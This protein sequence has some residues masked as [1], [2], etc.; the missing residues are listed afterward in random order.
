MTTLYEIH[1][2]KQS[3][4]KDTPI[5]DISDL[6]IR[7]EGITGL[8]GPNGSGKS[9]LLKVLSFLMPYDSGTLLYRGQPA[10][11]RES[12]IRRE[13][14]YLLQ[15]SFL[16]SR[17]VFE[18]IAFGLRLRGTSASEVKA[19]VRESLTRVGLD[20][21][22]FA[23]RQWYQ[24]SGGE[25][26]RVALAARLA[27]RPRVLLLDEPTA[28][29]DEASAQLIMAAAVTEAEQHGTAVIVATHDM[30]WLYEMSAEII[31]LYRGRVTAGAENILQGGWKQEGCHMVRSFPGGQTVY[32]D[33]T[34]TAAVRA[35][36]LDPSCVRV[37]LSRPQ[38]AD[39][40]NITAGHV[41]H[42]T[43]ERGRNSVLVTADVGGS[44]LKAR[45]PES[46]PLCRELY[47]QREVFY[48]FPYSSVRWL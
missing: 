37:S 48:I 22:E 40:V 7:S 16:L 9:T 8:V 44:L 26:Q 24:L 21:D 4:R 42:L 46:D 23:P 14:T 19:I 45:V 5:L 17:S 20:P 47:P 32:A 34:D 27:L 10:A 33:R 39:S 38:P 43:L 13:V 29:V 3:Y 28:N 18:N 41:V 11:G 15:N 1:N 12:V 30:P 35:A 6:T 2:L 31:G 25:V 36:A